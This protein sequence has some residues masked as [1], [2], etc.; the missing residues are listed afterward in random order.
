[1]KQNYNKKQKYKV[2]TIFLSQSNLRKLKI[3]KYYSMFKSIFFVYKNYLM[4][5]YNYEYLYNKYKHIL[6]NY[7][8]Y[9][10]DK[11]DINKDISYFEKKYIHPVN[12]SYIKMFYKDCNYSINKL[13]ETIKKI[14]ELCGIQNYDI[15]LII[16]NEYYKNKILNDYNNYKK[17]LI[18]RI[19][20]NNIKYSEILKLFIN[21]NF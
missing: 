19:N 15:N 6:K 13:F 18:K 1:M 21:N 11:N 9:I 3:N 16:N 14:I 10:F 5:K 7:S 12:I 8:F 20:P 4:L 2:R 17:N